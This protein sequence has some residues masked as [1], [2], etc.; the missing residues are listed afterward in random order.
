MERRAEC[1]MSTAVAPWNSIDA[2]KPVPPCK[3]QAEIDFCL[4]CTLPEGSCGR[5]DGHG[6]VRPRIRNV[7]GRTA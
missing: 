1:L 7:K 5:C 6:H 4:S 2:K 3:N